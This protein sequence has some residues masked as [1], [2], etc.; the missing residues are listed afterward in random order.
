MVFVLEITFGLIANIIAAWFSRRR[1]YRAD[2]GGAAL[3]GRGKM[4]SA[5]KKLEAMHEPSRLPEQLAAF[6]LTGA[7]GLKALFSTHPPIES[8]IARLQGER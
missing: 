6:G 3:A 2:A 4:V 1:E 5:L 7:G 8:R